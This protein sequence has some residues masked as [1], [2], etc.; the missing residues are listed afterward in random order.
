M[1][2]KKDNDYVSRKDMDIIFE[3]N[4]RAIELNNEVSGQ[5]EETIENLGD[6]KTAQSSGNVKLEEIIEQNEKIIQQNEELSKDI[7]LVKIFFSTT[8]V[9]IVIGIIQLL[10]HK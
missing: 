9:Q 6:I 1:V 5:Y 4:K 3:T 2:D 10:M 7:L 8:L